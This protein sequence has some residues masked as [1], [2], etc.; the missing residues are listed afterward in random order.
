M[1]SRRLVAATASS[2]VI[3]VKVL[4]VTPP[5]ED[6]YERFVESHPA[7]L[8]YHSLRYRDFLVSML[9]CTPRYVLAVMDGRIVGAFPL[10]ATDGPHGVVLNSLPYYG[11]NGGSLVSESSARDLLNEWYRHEADDPSVAAATVVANPFETDT[12]EVSHDLVDERLGLCTALGAGDG[13]AAE[14]VQQTIDSSAR[15]NVR[16]AERGAVAVAI[17]NESFPLLET[18]HRESMEVAGGRPKKHSFFEAVPDHF[19]AGLDYELY[20]ARV[21]GE[22]AAALLLFYYGSTVEYYV[23]AVRPRFRPEQPMAAVLHQAMTDATEAGYTRWNWGGSWVSQES[24]IRFKMKWGGKG[25]RYRYW[26]KVNRS[27]L[28]SLTPGE[29]TDAYPDFYVVPYS[30]LTPADSR[31]CS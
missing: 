7:A 3:R 5:R 29:L 19:R 12:G 28:L 6:D 10:M 13:T 9:G 31:A 1:A 11:S 24:L 20:V 8:L 27:D 15:R 16:K 30:A 22:P 26:T 25:G 2:T 4:D 21:G 23:P 14:R 17:E 18:L